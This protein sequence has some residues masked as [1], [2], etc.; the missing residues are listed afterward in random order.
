MADT[1]CQD[2]VCW[3][4]GYHV[5]DTLVGYTEVMW[6]SQETGMSLLNCVNKLQE[7][8][9]VALVITFFEHLKALA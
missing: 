3:E 2:P 5:L 7:R 1:G 6:L 4:T 9:S 8:R